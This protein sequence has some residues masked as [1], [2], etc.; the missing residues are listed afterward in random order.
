MKISKSTI[1]SRDSEHSNIK[2]VQW[3]GYKKKQKPNEF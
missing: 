3:T 2:I 1:D